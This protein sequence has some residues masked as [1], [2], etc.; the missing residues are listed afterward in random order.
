MDFHLDSLLNLPNVTVF[1]CQQQ[2]GFM[3]LKLE[4]LNEGI[5]CPH[6][7]ILPVVNNGDSQQKTIAKYQILIIE[8]DSLGGLTF[9]GLLL[10]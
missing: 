7:D 9:H 8:Q 10:L 4:L 6:F 2:E 3:I 5:N 1:S